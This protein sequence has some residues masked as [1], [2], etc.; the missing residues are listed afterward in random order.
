MWQH[1]FDVDSVVSC[2]YV[3]GT[4]SPKNVINSPAGG[5]SDYLPQ[6]SSKS[7]PYTREA[8]KCWCDRGQLGIVET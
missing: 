5:S 8:K 7:I 1:Q 2:S 3:H 6:I 4:I